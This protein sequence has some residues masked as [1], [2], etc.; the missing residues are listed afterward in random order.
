MKSN[1]F[2]GD[3][4]LQTDLGA[5]KQS[6]TNLLYTNYGERPFRPNLGGGLDHLLFE[7]LDPLTVLELDQSIRNVIQNWEPRVK[8]I[9]LGINAQPDQNALGITLAFSLLNISAPQTISIIL[10]RTR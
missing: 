2:T 8:I 4:R 6:L 7:Q 9:S 3:L 1:P 5:I 10:K